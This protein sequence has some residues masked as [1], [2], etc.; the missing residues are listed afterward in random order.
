MGSVFFIDLYFYLVY[1]FPMKK[2]INPSKVSGV[3]N[4]PSSKSQTIRALLIAT[5]A[6]G[7]SVIKNAL[8]SSDTI[9]CIKACKAFGAQITQDKTTLYIDSTNVKKNGDPITI[10]CENSGT[11]LYL[12]LGLAAYLECEVTFTGD[13]S[14]K[15]RPVGPL[16]QAYKD[17][18]CTVSDTNYPPF[19]I[20]GP[21]TKS[22]T[23]IDCPTSQ[24]L[25]SLLLAS[26]CA[27]TDV[28]I[29]TP[30][31]YEKPYVRLTLEWMNNQ[32]FDYKISEDLQHS[33][34]KGNQI[35]KPINTTI[36]GDY[37][38]ATFFFALAAISKTSITVNGLNKNDSQGDK[39][40]LSIL[41][42]MGCTINW[43]ENGVEVIGPDELKGG[44]FS[45]NSMPDA[46]PALSVVAC[47]SK[48]KVIF[49][50]V[51]Q[52]RLKET[53][54]IT[55]MRKN[56][57][58]LN[59]SVKELDDGIEINGNGKVK[60]AFVKGYDDHRIIMAMAIA[61]T[62][63]ESKVTIDNVD[64][65]SVTFPTFFELLDQLKETK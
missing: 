35:F 16:L 27:K 20:K 64:A 42:K 55:T 31:L 34:V 50:N 33:F 62:N 65:V 60:G 8:L 13:Q 49:N 3:I 5:L 25:S 53:D 44:T 37:S 48:E 1:I 6:N 17:L 29:I 10:D 41:E 57:E 4:I 58:K 14:L 12:A 18:G 24:Y 26:C 23:I 21:I 7:Q 61:A 9:S 63:A 11:T 52:A 2:I 38:S 32:N 45:L 59:V 43:T 22:K 28:E 30:L 56:L 36:S 51:A 39:Q 46:L 40:T 19:T 47:F 15:K 54:R